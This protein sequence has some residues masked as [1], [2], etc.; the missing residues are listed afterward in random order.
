M[1]AIAEEGYDGTAL[2]FLNYTDELPLFF[3]HVFP[4]LKEAGYRS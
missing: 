4:I 2:S 1:V 3:E